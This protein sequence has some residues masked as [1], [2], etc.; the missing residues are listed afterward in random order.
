LSPRPTPFPYT[1]LFRSPVGPCHSRESQQ[2]RCLLYL[3]VFASTKGVNMRANIEQKSGLGVS[4]KAV[5][6][7]QFAAALAFGTVACAGSQ[8]DRKSTRLNSSHVK[9]S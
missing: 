9:R 3:R 2:A 4:L 8:A 7:A 6:R 1:T 5:V